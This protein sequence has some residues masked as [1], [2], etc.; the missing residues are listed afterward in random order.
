MKQSTWC[1][2]SIAEFFSHAN[3]NA[4]R[5]RSRERDHDCISLLKFFNRLEH[6]GRRR[7]RHMHMH[8][9]AQRSKKSFPMGRHDE[10][11][12]TAQ[13]LGP[14]DRPI[15]PP[16]PRGSGIYSADD[17]IFLATIQKRKSGDVR[18]QLP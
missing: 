10:I 17:G 4:S 7:Q 1:C 18:S 14:A 5:K 2:A 8:T 13:A 6:P 3:A 9:H 15:A 12:E 11:P 16:S